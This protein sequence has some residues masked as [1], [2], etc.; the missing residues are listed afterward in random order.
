MKNNSSERKMEI[1]F[2]TLRHS[3]RSLLDLQGEPLPQSGNPADLAFRVGPW[4]HFLPMPVLFD[5]QGDD[6]LTSYP[7]EPESAKAQAAELVRRAE[8]RAD[9]CDDAG[10]ASL[11]LR[12]GD[13][14]FG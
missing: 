4:F 5:I 8:Q 12:H 2:C 3:I 9:T 11:P 14:E 7:D 13:G 6:V 1:T 10:A